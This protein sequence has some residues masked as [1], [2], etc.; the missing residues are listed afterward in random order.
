MNL[1]TFHTLLDIHA[2]T[3]DNT[4]TDREVKHR[5]GEV[6]RLAFDKLVPANSEVLDKQYRHIFETH[7]K[8]FAIKEYRSDSGF[9][10]LESKHY[11][12]NLCRDLINAAVAKHAQEVEGDFFP[13]S[14]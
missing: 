8:I 9:G 11:I 10:L 1:S 2:D 7:G 4:S 5:L 14:E 12:E 3:N 13:N 6:L